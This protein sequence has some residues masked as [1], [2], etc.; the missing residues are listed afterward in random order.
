MEKLVV[1]NPSQL[2]WKYLQ[3]SQ[4]TKHLPTLLLILS[5]RTNHLWETRAPKIEE[6]IR[7]NMHQ[8]NETSYPLPQNHHN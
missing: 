2:I 3:K 6:N 4:I 5:P 1:G 8:T 7:T